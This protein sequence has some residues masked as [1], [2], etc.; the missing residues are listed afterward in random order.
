[1]SSS[2]V[3]I[4]SLLDGLATRYRWQKRLSRNTIWQQWPEIAGEAIAKHSWP[5]KFKERDV[6]VLAVSDSVW[7]Q[8]L[9]LQKLMLLEAINRTL[10]PE[11]MV[12]DL[13]FTMENIDQVRKNHSATTSAP[14]AHSETV[15][16]QPE[17]IPETE[18]QNINQHAKA[19]TEPVKDEELKEVLQRAY[20]KSRFRQFADRLKN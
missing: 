9:S 18:K 20:V 5:M 19:V 4:G 10:P 8:Q 2:P 12:R 3:Q 11:S 7:M 16:I 17:K 14:K 6:L 13:H 1:M 15:C